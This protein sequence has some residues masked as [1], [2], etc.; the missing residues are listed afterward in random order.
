MCLRLSY[1]NMDI[2]YDVQ[3]FDSLNGSGQVAQFSLA[4]YNF[5]QHRLIYW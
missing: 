2:D 1:S 4:N 3:S 5:V